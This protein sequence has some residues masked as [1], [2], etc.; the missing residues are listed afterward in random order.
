MRR[1]TPLGLALAAGLACTTALADEPLL[2][3]NPLAPQDIRAAGYLPKTA[4]DGFQLPPVIVP[5]SIKRTPPATGELLRELVLRGN[6]VIS[7]D[8]LL[9]IARPWL[10]QPVTAADLEA[11]RIE[12]TRHYIG[13]GY[14]NSGARLAPEGLRD[15]VLT[16]DIIEGR[17]S[18]TR[19]SGLDGLQDAY[20][21]D[22]LLPV[23]NQPLNLNDLRERYQLLL[24]DPLIKRMNARLVPD[25]DPGSALLEIAVERHVPWYLH[26]RLNNYRPASIGE[27]SVA[28]D[29]GVRNVT[30]RGDLLRLTAQPGTNLDRITRAGI[31][32]SVPLNHTGTQLSLQFDAGQSSVVEEPLRAIDVTSRLTSREIGLSQLLFE[33][34]R[35]RTAVGL[36]WFDRSNRTWISGERFPFI[37]GEPDEGIE[38]QSL[39]FWQEYAYRSEVEVIALRSTFTTAKNNLQPLSPLAN[40]TVGDTGYRFWLGQAQYARRVSDNGTQL[41]ARATVQDST[42]KMLALDGLSIGGAAT[43]RGFRENHLIRDRGHILNLELDIP[44]MKSGASETSFNVIP[45]LDYG[46]GE[47]RDG[48]ADSIGSAGIALRWRLGNFAADLAWARHIHAS[49]GFKKA[50]STLQDNGVHF[51][52]SYSFG[53]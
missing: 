42:A 9:D 19:Y 48:V 6:N 24:D 37:A 50:G 8:E 39:R 40:A 10:N 31:G 22:K 47:N 34:L 30:G 17:I 44:V 1:L 16:I 25:T 52:V 35:H 43:V 26:L 21:T 46:K 38:T 49:D 45:F 14:I 15:G 36:T 27:K 28:I 29:A 23:A 4:P 53:K 2:R 33:N 20:L 5:D 11:L 7:R 51:Q 3:D 12:L 18:Q 41:I 32:W 13:R